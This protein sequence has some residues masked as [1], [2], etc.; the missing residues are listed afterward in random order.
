M[1][2]R[3]VI[4][5]KNKFWKWAKNEVTGEN[6]LR[7]DGPI[8]NESWIFD[9][10]TPKEFCNELKACKGAIEVWINSPGGDVFAAS[11]I[12]TM[13]ME[14]NGEVTV[15]ID[16]IA[17]SAASVIAMAG[18][19]TAMSPTSTIMI[20]N[21]WSGTVGDADEMRSCAEFLDEIKE[22]IINAYELKTGLSREK[23]SELMDAETYMNAKKALEL[24][25]CDEILFTE[26][27]SESSNAEMFSR[28]IAQRKF[29]NSIQKKFN[30]K[31]FNDGQ[32]STPPKDNGQG[33]G[34]SIDKLDAKDF[35][36]R[37]ALISH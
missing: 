14:Y 20:H 21:P 30:A 34:V 1:R 10:V 2:K 4:K 9:E 23:I 19:T 16:G 11:Q 32:N 26:D 33:L 5:L 13:L 29:L 6:V 22:S 25:F 36:K 37:L 35:Q 3:Q 28:R 31:E 8:A 15:K 18:T 12:Y 27:K 7:L 24:G 17:A